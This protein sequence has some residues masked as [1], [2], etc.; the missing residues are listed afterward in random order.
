MRLLDS[1]NKTRLQGGYLR[2]F[3]AHSVCAAEEHCVRAAEANCVRAAE[4]HSV[5]A[6][7]AHFERAL[8]NTKARV[9]FA[10]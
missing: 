7:E 9:L 8:R 4:A 10:T 5:R 3:K 6:A 2:A 1:S